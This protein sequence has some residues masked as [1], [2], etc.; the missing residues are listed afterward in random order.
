LFSFLAGLL[1]W[2]A[3]WVLG[4]GLFGWAVGVAVKGS[5]P[6]ALLAIP[7]AVVDLIAYVVH[8]AILVRRRLRQPSNSTPHA[9]ALRAGYAER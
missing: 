5:H 7:A 1:M 9:D 2:L 8:A 3:V 4:L 6:G